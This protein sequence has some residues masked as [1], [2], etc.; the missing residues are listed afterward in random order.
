MLKPAL[1]PHDNIILTSAYVPNWFRS[2]GTAEP[3][4]PMARVV[5]GAQIEVPYSDWI[6]ACIDPAAL[7][8]AKPLPLFLMRVDGRPTVDAGIFDKDS[9]VDEDRHLQHQ[10][11][12]RA[13]ANPPALA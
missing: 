4:L 7:L 1:A 8:I 13:A 3:V 11:D 10:R 12:Q 5:L 9:V 2:P 6:D